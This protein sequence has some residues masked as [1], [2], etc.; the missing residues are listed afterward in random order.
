MYFEFTADHTWLD[1][2]QST[3]GESFYNWTMDMDAKLAVKE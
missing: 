1:R 2:T 3:W